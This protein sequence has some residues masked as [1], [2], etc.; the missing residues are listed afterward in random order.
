M[1]GVEAE[2][3]DEADRLCRR[4]VDTTDFKPDD[5]F[6]ERLLL[7]LKAFPLG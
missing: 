3:A 2:A 4:K 5:R 7:C 1:P 6:M